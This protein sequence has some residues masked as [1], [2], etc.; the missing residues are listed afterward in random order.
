[1][2]TREQRPLFTNAPK[3]LMLK[4][5]TLHNGDYSIVGFED[6]FAIERKGL[7]DF[8]GYV[9]AERK[10]TVAKLERLRD[11]EFKALVVEVD[12]DEL[13]FGSMHS[14]IGAEVIRA[15]LTSFAVRYGVHVYI[16]D[17]RNKIERVILDWAIK[18]YN[19]KKEVRR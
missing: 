9:G 17:D 7:S 2:D 15:G 13:Y 5:D 1:M 8:L 14:Q 10:K 19:I 3:G 18:Y 12:E 16:T 11:Y 6:K 4:R